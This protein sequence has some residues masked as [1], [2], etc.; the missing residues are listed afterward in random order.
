MGGKLYTSRLINIKYDHIPQQSVLLP[1][2]AHA[3]RFDLQVKA[4][5]VGYFMGAGDDVPAALAQMGCNVTILTDHDLELSN[6]KRFDAVVMGIRAYNTKD[7]LAFH[8]QQLL[9]YV[10]WGG[11]MIVQYNTSGEIVVDAD[12]L[13]PFPLKIS[14]ARVTDEAAE[15]R[16]QLPDH[17]AL[18]QPNKLSAN[19]F[20][21]WVQERGLY[22]PSEWDPAFEAPLSMNDQGEKAAEGSLLVA[23]YGKGYYVYTGISFFRELPAGVPGAYRLFANLLSLGR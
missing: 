13:A 20:N 11:T 6:L 23:K 14:R 18:N 4:K 15:V 12:K 8:Q 7:A 19:D 9:D 16:F 1:A 17:R 10:N 3:A 5:N 2:T 21:G 22:F